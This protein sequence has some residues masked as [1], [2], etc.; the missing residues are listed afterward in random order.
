MRGDIFEV[1]SLRNQVKRATV[2]LKFEFYHT[3]NE[4]MRESGT[5]SWWKNMKKIM[6]KKQQ[7]HQ[8]YRASRIKQ[9]MEMLNY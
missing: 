3:R 4:A 8:T 1:R 7:T 6:G 9:R 5:Q 2:K